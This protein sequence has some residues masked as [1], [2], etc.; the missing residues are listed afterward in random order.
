M[1]K[2]FKMALKM[3]SLINILM[4][5]VHGLLRKRK[6]WKQPLNYRFR[7][8][9]LFLLRVKMKKY[10]SGTLP[11]TKTYLWKCTLTF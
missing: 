10:S 7:N 5:L 8:P 9:F 1:N 3:V 11:K 4:K 2:I 6:R